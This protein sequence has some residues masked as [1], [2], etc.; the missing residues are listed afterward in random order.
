MARRI[1]LSLLGLGAAL[2]VSCGPSGKAPP[3]QQAVYRDVT[4]PIA[5]AALFDIG[6]LRGE[7]HVLAHYPLTSTPCQRLRFAFGA[8]NAQLFC[9]DHPAAAQLV[10]QGSLRTGGT[11]RIL[12]GFDPAF[13]APDLRVIWIAHDGDTAVL[14]AADGRAGFVLNR[15]AQL[16]AD[17]WAAVREMLDFNGFDPSRLQRP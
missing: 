5:A 17:R 15:Q 14:G 16:S 3:A 1:S 4:R 9:L 7:W 8:Q 11:G 10:Q 13:E 2:L 6:K 12:L